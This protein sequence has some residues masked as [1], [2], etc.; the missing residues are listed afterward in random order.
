MYENTVAQYGG[1][2]PAL[3]PIYPFEGTFMAT[4]PA[5]IST[6]APADQQEAAK[7]FRNHLLKDDV[8]K[9]AAQDGLRPANGTPA[10]TAPFDGAQ[11]AIVFG[12]QSAPTLQALQTSWQSARKP[13]NLVMV[14]DVSGSMSGDKI[15]SM[16]TAAAQFVQQM[17]DNDYLTVIAFSDFADT[18]IARQR[19]ADVREDAVAAI[20]SLQVQGGT[21]L[22]D[23]IASG[24]DAVAASTSPQRANL[25]IVLTDGLDTKSRSHAFGSILIGLASANNT[26][27]YTIAYGGDA[28]TQKLSDLATHS[29][30]SFYQGSEADIAQI[31]E[32]MSTAFGG[33]AGIGR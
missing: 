29:N 8:Q 16:R 1:G 17:G 11:P 25:M 2:D 27:V 14:L 30:G 32:A 28:D 10:L 23:A 18:L 6:S 7:L 3:V 4:H 22:Y 21:A 5:C 12:A 9:L 19:V 20:Q 31:Y 13:V 15:T 26:S 24:A 33:S